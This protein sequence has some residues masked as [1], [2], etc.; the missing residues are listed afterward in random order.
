M[1]CLQTREA[2][3]LQARA[4]LRLT[5]LAEGSPLTQTDSEKTC[6]RV[7][8]FGKSV[9]KHSLASA[10]RMPL[11]LLLL[12]LLVSRPSQ[13]RQQERHDL[14]ID[15]DRRRGSAREGESK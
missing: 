7:F 11:L 3:S 1:A 12:L 15:Y 10:S 8:H 6:S 5:L 14:V 13:E 4:S 2:S 9:Q